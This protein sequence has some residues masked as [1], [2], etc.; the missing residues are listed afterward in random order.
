MAEQLSRE[1]TL[2]ILKGAQWQVVMNDFTQS[3]DVLVRVGEHWWRVCVID[4]QGGA[5]K[6]VLGVDVQ[7]IRHSQA[8]PLY[9]YQVAANKAVGG[10]L[11]EEGQM[12]SFCI[13]VEL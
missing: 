5:P 9:P 3:D 8:I 1:R 12:R 7:P 11:K 4:T 13:V 10:L 2:E 6:T